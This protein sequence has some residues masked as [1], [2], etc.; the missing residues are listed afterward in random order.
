MRVYL[1]ADHA[2]L[3]LKGAVIA[4]LRALGHEPIDCGPSAYDP[5]DDYP[6]Y[7]LLAAPRTAAD[8]GGVR[9]AAAG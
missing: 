8:G 7:V 4:H 9:A 6:R 1:G 2:G 5:Q 3:E